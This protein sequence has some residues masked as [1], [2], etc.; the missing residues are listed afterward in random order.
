MRASPGTIFGGRPL[1]LRGL[2]ESSPHRKNCP[3]F[4]IE[5]A[6]FHVPCKTIIFGGIV[7]LLL[8]KGVL[9]WGMIIGVGITFNLSK[10]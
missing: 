10:R 8:D 1:R 7:E 3:V 6:G 4:S 5:V 9:L 2:D